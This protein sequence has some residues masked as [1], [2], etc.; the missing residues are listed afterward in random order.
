MVILNPEVVDLL[1]DAKGLHQQALERLE[2]GDI[3][4]AAEKAWCAT[5]RSTSA[6]V[7]ALEGQLPERTPP[8]SS[9][10]KRLGNQN[11]DIERLGMVGRYYYVQGALHRDCFYHGECDLEQDGQLIRAVQRYIADT[12]RLAGS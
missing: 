3:R 12:E 11:G 4:D 7:L 2:A 10:L 5:L 9:A 8:I 6:L 1:E